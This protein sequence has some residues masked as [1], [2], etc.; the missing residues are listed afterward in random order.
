VGRST[1]LASVRYIRSRRTAS[2]RLFAGSAENRDHLT[3]RNRATVAP[4]LLLALLGCRGD[5]ENS[6]IYRV[7]TTD[8]TIAFDGDQKRTTT[9]PG[10]VRM[11]R[12]PED[13]LIQDGRLAVGGRDYGEVARRDE[14]AVVGGKVKVNGN[15]RKPLA[16]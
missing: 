7:E 14:I 11:V 8:Y 2:N 3:H 16:P 15:E 1:S 4:C 13:L 9:G 12:I 10:F 5:R 6:T